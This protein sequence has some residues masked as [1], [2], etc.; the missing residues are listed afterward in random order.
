[1]P[2]VLYLFQCSLMFVL[3]VWICTQIPA[4]SAQILNPPVKSTSWWWGILRWRAITKLFLAN[5]SH[6]LGILYPWM[7]FF[8]Q[9]H[10]DIEFLVYCLESKRNHKLLQNPSPSAMSFPRLKSNS[11]KLILTAAQLSCCLQGRG[12]LA[13]HSLQ[14]GFMGGFRNIQ[15][16]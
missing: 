8:F 9:N 15:T 7:P 1:M 3:L 12:K 2:N 11:S 13:A 6:L 16:H 14:C 4:A 5:R 10:L